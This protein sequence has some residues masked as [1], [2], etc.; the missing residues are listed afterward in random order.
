MRSTRSAV[1]TAACALAAASAMLVPAVLDGD[2]GAAAGR[3]GGPAHAAGAPRT[4]SA[5]SQSAAGASSSAGTGM[6]SG[7]DASAQAAATGDCK[8]P[9]A[10]LEPSS[11][12]GPTIDKI[13]K[14][15]YLIAGVDQNSYH[16]GYSDPTTGTLSGFDIDLVQ[17]IAKNI[18]GS[19]NKVN[20][21]TI[22]TSQ[23]ISALQRASVDVVVRT[24]TINCSRINQVAFSTAY[25]AAGQQVLAPM[26]SSIT[27]YNTSLHGKKVCTAEGST[28]QA[29]LDAEK[30]GAKALGVT[31]VTVP[32]QLDCLVKLQLDQVDAV[33]TDNALAAGQ[34]AQDPTVHLV[35]QPFTRELY[36]VAM[37]KNDTDLVRR[38]NQI[39][40]DYRNGPWQKSYRTWLA[41]LLSAGI[42]SPPAPVYKKG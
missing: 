13:K 21:R 16:W 39:L 42:P 38:V 3:G 27:G 14:R 25:F 6:T 12:S 40:V 33:I 1:A 31:E 18:L 24:M 10:S 8:Q 2:A 26:D 34:A 35:G 28:G 23:R 19:A 36:G 29:A 22:P 32:N 30:D 11:A 7:I 17:A 20:Y 9:E 37:S 41:G 15:G 4:A 5:A